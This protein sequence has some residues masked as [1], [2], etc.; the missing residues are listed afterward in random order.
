MLGH[1]GIATLAYEEP[2]GDR[3][4]R[5]LAEI[6]AVHWV[7]FR[8]VPPPEC[9]IE[10]LIV[11]KKRLPQ[12]RDAKRGELTRILR[13]HFLARRVTF[14][15]ESLRLME[16][17]EKWRGDDILRHFV[18]GH[19]AFEKWMAALAA[20]FDEEPLVAMAEDGNRCCFGRIGGDP[21]MLRAFHGLMER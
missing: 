20:R 14:A 7:G 21:A 8:L 4:P 1:A 13:L 6:A 19:P 11:G 10:N 18:T 17:V 15:D 9:A 12:F 16:W 5:H 2:L 3:L